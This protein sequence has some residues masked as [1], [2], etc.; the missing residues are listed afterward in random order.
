[1]YGRCASAV[2][3]FPGVLVLLILTRGNRAA[4]LS[5]VPT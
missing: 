2:E 1:M 4:A 5:E 3:R